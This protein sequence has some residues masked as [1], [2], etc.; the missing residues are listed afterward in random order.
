MKHFS[1][2]RPFFTFLFFSSLSLLTFKNLNAATSN[3]T[4]PPGEVAAGAITA[5]CFAEV[6]VSVGSSC[7]VTLNPEQIDAGST[8]SEGEPLTFSLDNPG[9]YAPGVYTVFLNVSNSTSTNQCWST[10]TVEDKLAP[11]A[12]CVSNVNVSLG[13]DGTVTAL[14]EFL[15]A[16]SFDNCE[17]NL[18][19]SSGPTEFGCTDVGET[20][21]LF[22]TVEDNGGNSNTCFSEVSIVDPGN[23]CSNQSPVAV[24][25][26]HLNA[27]VNEDCEVTLLPEFLDAGSFDPDGDPITL[28]LDNPGPYPP[29]AYTVFLT[30]SD[31][32]LSNSCFTE[33]IV[34]DK[35]TP[36][37]ICVSGLSVS[38][39]SDGTITIFPE[40][41][42]AGSFDNCDLSY[43]VTDGPTTFSCADVGDIFELTLTVEDEG[44][45]ANSC[46]S[47]VNVFDTDEVC[48]NDT[49]VA[50]CI[51]GL[52]VAVGEDCES[53]LLLPGDFDAGSFDPNGDP[54]TYSI[55]NAGPFTP[56]AYT[57]TLTVSDGSLSNS[58][59]TEVL[60]EDSTAP[61][62]VCVDGLSVNLGTD[63]TTAIFPEDL[64]GGSF[65]N[66]DLSLSIDGGPITFDCTDVGDTFE[67]ILLVEDEGGNVNSCFSLVNVFDADGVCD[68]QAPIASC[69]NALALSVNEDCEFPLLFPEDVDAASFDPD[70]D[71]ITLNLD[72][73]GPFI[74]GAYT[75]TLTVSD[76]SLS[77]TCFTEIIVEDKTSPTAICVDGLTVGLGEEGT[78]TIFPE[79]LDGGSFDNCTSDLNFTGDFFTVGCPDV[80]DVFELTMTVEDEA[81]N[82]NSCTSLVNVLDTDGICS[83]EAPVAICVDGIGASVGADCQL[84]LFATDIDAGSFDPDGD[85]ITL[86]LDN[87]G[88]YTPGTYTVTLIVSDGTF[89]NSCETELIVT[90]TD[91]D[92][93][94]FSV[95]DGD[96]DD[97][98]DSIYPGAPELCDGVDNNCNNIIDEPDNISTTYEWIEAVALADLN[99]TSGDDGGYADFT[100][101]SATLAIGNNYEITLT[102]GYATSSYNERWRVYI[103]LNQDGV[104]SNP[105]ERVVQTQGTGPQFANI[106]LPDGTLTGSTRMRVVM[107]YGSFEN[108]CGDDFE[109]EIEDYTIVIANCEDVPDCITYCESEGESTNF[110]WI[111]RVRFR[112]IIN[113]SGDDGGYGD[114]TA[115]S[116][117]VAPGSTYNIRLRP[118]FSGSSYQEY[119]RVWIDWNQDGDFNNTDELMVEENDD[120]TIVTPLTVPATAVAGTTR[121]RVAM[122]YNQYADPCGNFG[123]GEVEDYSVNVLSTTGLIAAEEEMA[124]SQTVKQRSTNNR[125][126]EL[127]QSVINTPDA[128]TLSLRLAPNPASNVVNV[129]INELTKNADLTIT[130]QMGRVVWHQKWDASQQDLALDVQNLGLVDGVYFVSLQTATDK[131]TQRLVITH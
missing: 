19:I 26:S 5:I 36:T 128:S 31:G 127:P 53:P 100:A 96:C 88:P 42:D 114:Y 80:G 120:G 25:V 54:L 3:L 90:A 2:V 94:G 57:V 41:L 86:S 46:V 118:G 113:N 105:A 28:S 64:D 47:M 97:N 59:F 119:W 43:S 32:S 44:G 78:V 101:L 76:G 22:L 11:T 14:P 12:I 38:L 77:N 27:S 63:G 123:E 92:E 52:S 79:D 30:V 71:P 69:I 50:L 23:F 83:N 116:T 102:P 72:N 108:A 6:Y 55:D 126:Y 9:P 110:E 103:D 99:N 68:N 91:I 66:C 129:R 84:T 95:C 34:E 93:D 58:C 81:G 104:F 33:V 117:D 109:G 74:P 82:T 125:D 124:H 39:G 8:D 13:A 48:D 20:F 115:L 24:C 98:D 17:V 111:R 1:F 89:S 87:P 40:D 65:D 61:T 51:N 75:V 73:T 16:G 107:S 60:V 49:P 21:T 112:S 18:S 106:V 37:A 35:T 7:E 131:L 4:E 56:G 130:D 122:Q 45:N 62:A 121:M 85:P 29:G 15:D 67:L 70:G 10:V